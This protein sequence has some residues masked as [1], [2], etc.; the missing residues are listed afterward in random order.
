M[1]ECLIR[2]QLQVILL[3]QF[4]IGKEGVICV[5]DYSQLSLEGN[6]Q[7][8]QTGKGNTSE[9]FGGKAPTSSAT[10]VAKNFA[11]HAAFNET[12]DAFVTADGS[13]NIFTFYL[14]GN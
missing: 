7:A 4:L 6:T 8:K 14:T 13:G 9:Q 2:N 10:Q 1:A 12:G 5:V 3:T 11:M